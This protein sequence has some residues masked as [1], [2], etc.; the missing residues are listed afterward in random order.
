[1]NKQI[2]VLTKKTTF[3]VHVAIMF[4][5][6][7]GCFSPTNHTLLIHIISVLLV[8]IHWKFN[9]GTCVLTDLEYFIDDKIKSLNDSEAARMLKIQ[10]EPFTGRIFKMLGLSVTDKQLNALIYLVLYLSIGVSILRLN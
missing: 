5:M 10:Q 4:Y 3:A 7:F 6:I 9:N 8:M 2:L 1:M